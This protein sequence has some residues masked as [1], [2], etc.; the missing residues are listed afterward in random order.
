MSIYFRIFNVCG[1]ICYG[2]II[3]IIFTYILFF[4][5]LLE[6]IIFTYYLFFYSGIFTIFFIYYNYSLWYNYQWFGS[7][8]RVG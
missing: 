6:T 2:D 4:I 3:T 8:V 1:F 5:V 7:T